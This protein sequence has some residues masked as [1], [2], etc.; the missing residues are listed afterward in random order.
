MATKLVVSN[1]QV[2]N[3]NDLDGIKNS[4]D[5]FKSANHTDLDII[6][7]SIVTVNTSIGTVNT[8]VG[9]VNTSV[10]TVK[11]AIDDTNS[12]LEDVKDKLDT[13]NANVQNSNLTSLLRADTTISSVTPAGVLVVLPWKKRSIIHQ[14]TILKES[15][16]ATKWSVEIINKAPPTT[17]RNVICRVASY[18]VYDPNRLDVLRSIPYVN[19][20]NAD[21]LRI[22]VYPDVGTS[23][24][25]AVIVSGE[26]AK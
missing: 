12:K 21:E 1:F 10:G 2:A 5:N 18:E 19:L 24:Q 13:I 23:N 16:S 11:S 4:L 15:G 14:I 17:E 9:T 6:N 7:T 8:S 26:Q 25:F 22:K 20:D 3:H